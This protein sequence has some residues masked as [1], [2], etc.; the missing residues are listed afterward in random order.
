MLI[1]KLII[2]RFRKKEQNSFTLFVIKSIKK[3]KNY[4]IN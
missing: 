3:K 1:I 2:Y 4:I